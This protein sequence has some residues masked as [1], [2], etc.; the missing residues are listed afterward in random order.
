MFDCALVGR[1]FYLPRD[2]EMKLQFFYIG[3]LCRFIDVLLEA[4][5]AQHIF[6]VGN[7]EPVSVRQWAGLCYQA[8]GKKRPLPTC[9]RTLSSGIISAFMTM[10]IT[11]MFPVNIRSCPL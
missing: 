11:W 10:S 5:P 9:M 7:G 4:R 3:D 8:A 1:T 6:N 2:G